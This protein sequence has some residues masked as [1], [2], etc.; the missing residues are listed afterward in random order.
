MNVKNIYQIIIILLII[1]ISFYIYNKYLKKSK[2]ENKVLNTTDEVIKKTEQIDGAEKTSIIENIKYFNEDAKGNKFILEAR[3]AEN[4][5][6]NPNY[7]LLSDVSG[8]INFK[9]KSEIY[10]FSKFAYYDSINFDT[11][12]FSEVSVKYENNNL[13]SENLDIFFK[14]NFGI[15]YNNINLFSDDTNLKADKITF[16][17]MNG[18]VNINMYNPEDKV[19]ILNKWIYGNYKKI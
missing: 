7:F 12:F 10:I 1:L 14:D 8:I 11:K 6:Q 13:E 3:T 2:V 15:M 19:S 16:D 9:N 17:L 5:D 18:D 4:V